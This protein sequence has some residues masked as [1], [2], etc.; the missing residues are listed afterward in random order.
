MLSQ[1]QHPRIVQ[2]LGAYLL[3]PHICIVE[4]LAEGGSLHARLHARDR[5]GHKL[6]PP[7]TLEQVGLP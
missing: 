3:P 5:Q 7:L 2:F 4:E 6:H 1:L